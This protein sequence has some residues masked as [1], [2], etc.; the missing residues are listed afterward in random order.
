MWVDYVATGLGTLI[1]L[2]VYVWLCDWRRRL[3]PSNREDEASGEYESIRGNNET[4]PL[5]PADG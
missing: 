2:V 3:L 4:E 5:L 1:V